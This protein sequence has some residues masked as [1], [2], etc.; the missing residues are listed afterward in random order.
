MNYFEGTYSALPTPFLNGSI[1]RKSFQRF[2]SWQISQNIE[3]LV[4]NG[5][6]AES[7]TLIWAEVEELF[8]LAKE[9][10]GGRVPI[11]VGTG[12][13]STQET[14]E[15]SLKAEKLGAD[16]LLIVTPY[17]NKPPQRGLVA[18]YRTV[19]QSVKLPILLYNVPG[20]TGVSMT[21]RTIA[22]IATFPN[23]VGCKEAT[24][25]LGLGREILDSVSPEFNLVSGDDLTFVNLGLLGGRGV[26]SVL[27]NVI[28][29]E[30][31]KLL[32]RARTKDESALADFKRFER[33]T[34]LLF[35][36]PNP[37]P[38]KAA[39]HA[40]GLFDTDEMRLPLV[41]MES[42]SRAQLLEEMKGLGLI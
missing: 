12:S 10:S 41:P 1:D 4:V 21:A 20:R 36:E 6:T 19:A 40:M 16:G 33:L 11:L 9:A 22:E 37:I 35:S 17:Y 39:L 18:H 26:I 28:P 15:K 24:G 30:T 3:G 14:V 29:A 23:V 34:Q 8:R 13:N 42:E 38:V 32:K 27:S 5:T 7:P 25:D 31:A 2:V